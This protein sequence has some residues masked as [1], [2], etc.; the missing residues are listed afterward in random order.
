MSAYTAHDLT[1]LLA[2]ARIA[3][4]DHADSISQSRR[5][6]IEDLARA[7]ALVVPWNLD[8]HVGHINHR[9]GGN[10]YA[11]LTRQAL[12]AE[13]GAYCREWWSETR[14][15]RDPATLSDEDAADI[16]FGCHTGESFTDERITIAGPQ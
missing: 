8:V 1:R 14:D 6:L 13:V 10:L 15:G 3:L 2:R 12:M 16:Y 7:E 5:A 4:Q 9:E 11:A